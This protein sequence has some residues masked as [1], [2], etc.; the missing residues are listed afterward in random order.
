MLLNT[1][2]NEAAE[3]LN[4]NEGKSHLAEKRY[5]TLLK[6]NCK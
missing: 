5:F 6:G 2:P 3:E 1:A 4:V